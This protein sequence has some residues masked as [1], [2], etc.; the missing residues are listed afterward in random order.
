MRDVSEFFSCL[1]GKIPITP[2]F[3][4]LPAESVVRHAA[5]VHAIYQVKTT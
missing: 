5:V 1:K 4:L 2:F 3:P